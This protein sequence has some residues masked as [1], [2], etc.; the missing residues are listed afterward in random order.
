MSRPRTVMLMVGCVLS[1]LV[2]GFSRSAE[3]PVVVVDVVAAIQASDAWSRED[4]R[5]RE[6]G[7]KMQSDEWRKAR[8]PWIQ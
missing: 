4:A 2:L 8:Q 1:A 5:L 3:G 6:I 7:Q